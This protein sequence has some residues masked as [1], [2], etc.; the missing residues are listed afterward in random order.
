[1]DKETGERAPWPQQHRLWGDDEI[2][3]Y[4]IVENGFFSRIKDQ[5][6]QVFSPGL[7]GS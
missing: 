7:Q 3:E 2:K 1:M 6:L 5:I 4:Q